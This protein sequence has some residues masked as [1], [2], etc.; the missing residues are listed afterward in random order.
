MIISIFLIYV[1]GWN[2]ISTYA[3]WA[4]FLTIPCD[5]AIWEKLLEN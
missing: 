5:Y 1:V 2:H 3:L 4:L